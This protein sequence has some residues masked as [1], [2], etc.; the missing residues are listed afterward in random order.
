MKPSIDSKA[1]CLIVDQSNLDRHGTQHRVQAV[2]ERHTERVGLDLRPV[3]NVN[4]QLL[5]DV[6]PRERVPDGQDAAEVQG[7]A[8]EL[9]ASQGATAGVP[10][11]GEE[12][13]LAAG[14]EVAGIERD[15][16]D[17]DAIVLG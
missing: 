14:V 5:Q 4:D 2:C 12:E 3:V 8:D 11:D 15:V 9:A 10:R 7:V 17:D 1:R 16:G 6:Q 13:V